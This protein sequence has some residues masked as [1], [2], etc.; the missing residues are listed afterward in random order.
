MQTQ[1]SLQCQLQAVHHAVNPIFDQPLTKVNHKPQFQVAEPEIREN[2][3]LKNRV[4]LGS[5]FA[6]NNDK[7]IHQQIDF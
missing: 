7:I 1:L 5:R 3:S 2:L 6:F 4:K